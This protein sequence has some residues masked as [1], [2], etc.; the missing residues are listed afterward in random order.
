MCGATAGCTSITL[1][2]PLEFLRVR[3]AMEKDSFSYRDYPQAVRKIY[4][5]EGMRGFYRG[6]LA[7]MCGIFVYHGTGFFVFTRIK[8]YIKKRYPN[9]F[10]LWYV[11]FIV[12]AISSCGQFIAYPF[13]M[14]KKRMQGQALLVER[15]EITRLMNYS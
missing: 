1:T 8:E 11:D 12:G 10:K 2:T 7:S 14:V 9:S 13:D 5:G 4:K 3:M 6:Y 15:R